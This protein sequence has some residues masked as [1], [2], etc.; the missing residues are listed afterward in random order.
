M[1][2]TVDKIN[3]LLK[4]PSPKNEGD[5]SDVDKIN[6]LLS[7]ESEPTTFDFD[8]L[9]ATADPDEVARSAAHRG[10]DIAPPKRYGGVTLLEGLGNVVTAP[11]R[12]IFGSLGEAL[13]T[14]PEERPDVRRN[15]FR[16]E[17][18]KEAWRGETGAFPSEA[19]Y[20]EGMPITL[21]SGRG[22]GVALPGTKTR[23]LAGLATD[24]ALDP[25][26]ALVLGVPG[27]AARVA[28]KVPEIGKAK[29]GRMV[30]TRER[31]PVALNIPFDVP[32]PILPKVQE[33]IAQTLSDVGTKIRGKIPQTDEIL[34]ES[35]EF[36]ARLS[37]VKK[38]QRR[39]LNVLETYSREIR[40]GLIKNAPDTPEGMQAFEKFRRQLQNIGDEF[41]I[42]V[43]DIEQA[44]QGRMTQFVPQSEQ[45]LFWDLY[46]RPPN[47]L[48][49]AETAEMHRINDKMFLS[50]DQKIGD[51]ISSMKAKIAVPS[52]IEEASKLR[53]TQIQDDFSSIRTTS[54]LRSGMAIDRHPNGS[55]YIDWEQMIYETTDGGGDY[56]YPLPI[57]L[58]TKSDCSEVLGARMYA[59]NTGRGY[60]WSYM[61]DPFWHE[62]I[63][64]VNDADPEN[65]SNYGIHYNIPRDC[66]TKVCSVSPTIKD[67]AGENLE[68][69][70]LLQP[71][72]DGLTPIWSAFYARIDA[73]EVLDSI[74]TFLYRNKDNEIYYDKVDNLGLQGKRPLVGVVK[75]KEISN[76]PFDLFKTLK[77]LV[78]VSSA[79]PI[80]T[81]SCTLSDPDRDKSTTFSIAPLTRKVRRVYKN[82]W[83]TLLQIKIKYTTTLEETTPFKFRAIQAFTKR[84]KN[85][86]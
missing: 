27:K 60:C 17:T 49:A 48:N 33:H 65:P 6:A 16:P 31:V 64:F 14:I 85:K 32:K 86:R 22:V 59:G 23:A 8:S 25:L 7:S 21:H 34:Y 37:D 75:T 66:F 5:K 47:T 82:F 26:N 36:I 71:A 78:L 13:G 84:W 40:Q 2:T 54:Q 56:P 42:N 72:Q 83:H 10:R 52:F 58:A 35:P 67:Y 9:R 44:A 12:D 4:S 57:I 74:P 43:S 3:A 70:G 51:M 46:N 53:G 38:N 50:L 19:L 11:Q 18:W 73:Q 29:L 63:K 61:N 20:P 55:N 41:G 76:G 79:S 62:L 39:A 45:R 30:A 28:T 15:I 24:I 68:N 1:P 77:Q 69:Y 80:G 81:I